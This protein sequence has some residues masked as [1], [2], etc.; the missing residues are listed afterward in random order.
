MLTS[1]SYNYNLTK[2]QN[3]T[4]RKFSNTKRVRHY[5]H[6]FIRPGKRGYMNGSNI[7]K[8]TRRSIRRKINSERLTVDI[9]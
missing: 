2:Y 5:S 6:K 4:L 1:C 7:T 8:E 9:N 3:K